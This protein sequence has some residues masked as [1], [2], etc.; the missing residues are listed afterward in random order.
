MNIASVS[1]SVS[2]FFDGLF[3]RFRVAPPAPREVFVTVPMPYAHVDLESPFGKALTALAD[4]IAEAD[5]SGTPAA[6]VRRL[7]D[8]ID[9]IA[10]Q[11]LT[12]GRPLLVAAALHEAAERLAGVRWT[13]CQ[14]L[15]QALN[16]EERT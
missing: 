1:T 16:D 7:A 10:P 3:G 15:V 6:A 9:A 13:E 11:T 8:C 14:R 5:G 4:A 12:T 2:S